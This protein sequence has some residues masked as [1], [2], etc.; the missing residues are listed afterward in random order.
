[1]TARNGSS[2]AIPIRALRA[3]RNF[4]RAEANVHRFS[5]DFT[6]FREPLRVRGITLVSVHSEEN[7]NGQVKRKR[8]VSASIAGG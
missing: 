8:N 3:S 7:G 6:P 2:R 5:H 4:T 1:V